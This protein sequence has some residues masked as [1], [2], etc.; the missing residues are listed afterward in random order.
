MSDR[1]YKLIE[2]T[3]TS[4]TSVEDATQTA[5][6]RASETVRHMRWFEVVEIRGSIDDDQVAQWQVTLKVGFAL[7]DE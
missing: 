3:G 2:L 1:V 4:A 6:A 5:I 7:E